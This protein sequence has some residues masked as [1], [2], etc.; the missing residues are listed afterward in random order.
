MAKLL[1]IGCNLKSRERSRSR[2]VAGAFLDEYRRLHPTDQVETVDLYRDDIPHI[3]GD[4]LT[5]WDELRKGRPLE[6]LS[7]DQ[8]R[9]IRRVWEL[10]D[11][12]A[13]ADKYVFATPMWNLGFP[14]EMKMYI[15]CIC[16]VGKTFRY[17]AEGAVGLLKGRQKKCMHI[18]SSGGLHFGTEEDHSLPYLRSI[19]KFL[20]LE[21]FRSVVLEGVDAAPERAR[22]LQSRAIAEAVTAAATF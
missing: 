17:T 5:G 6:S 18:H 3:D 11:Q 2:T 10:A 21:D 4:I 19:M 14:A 12:F 22:E 1:Y 9:K 13:A 20:G 16:S 15:D 7:P 8:Q